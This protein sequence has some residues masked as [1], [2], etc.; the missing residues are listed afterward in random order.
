MISKLE[1]IL[2]SKTPFK[3]KHFIGRLILRNG[4]KASVLF[5]GGRGSLKKKAS[6]I[7][8]GHMIQVTLAPYKRD[9]SMVQTKEWTLVWAPEKVRN[10]VK[11]FFLLCFFM[12][13]VDKIAP[14]HDFEDEEFSDL[15]SEGIFRVLSNSLYMLNKNRVDQFCDAP[16]HVFAFLGKL[17]LHQGLFPLRDRCC[18][19]GEILRLKTAVNLV[20]SQGGFSCDLC[21]SSNENK[22]LGGK[23]ML[24]ALDLVASVEFRDFVPSKNVNKPL[25]FSLFDYF[26]YQYQLSPGSFK[27]L[28]H[29]S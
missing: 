6:Y 7:D 10:S 29:L 5:Y 14:P 23:E 3:D 26:C 21:S 17:L 27:T 13:V 11:R 16:F 19:C 15:S 4:K 18:F 22:H 25:S 8:S 28:R 1:G 12:E 9:P 20:A 24:Q 2:V